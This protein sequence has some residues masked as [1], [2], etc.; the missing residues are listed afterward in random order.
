MKHTSDVGEY[1]KNLV[2]KPERKNDL[3]DPG[4]GV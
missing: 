3:E 2:E 4:L 1:T